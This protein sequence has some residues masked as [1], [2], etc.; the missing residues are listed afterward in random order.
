MEN[1]GEEHNMPKFLKAFVFSAVIISVFLAGCGTSG[2]NGGSSVVVPP[3]TQGS[4]SVVINTPVANT[5]GGNSGSITINGAG[6]T[7]PFPLYSRWFYDYAFV[8]PAVK[9]NYQAIGSGGG[10]KQITAKTVDFGASDAILT[11]EQLSAAPNLHMFPSVAG[12]EVIAYN[13]SGADGKSLTGL[14]KFPGTSLADIYLGKIKKWNDPVLQQANPDVQLP[15]KDIIV[16]HRSDGSGTTF[17]F[18]DYLS[19]ISPEWQSKV[20]NATSVQWPVGLGGKGNDGVAG[21]VSQNDGALGY[22]ELAY[23]L[24]NKLA[25]GVPANKSGNY[26]NPKDPKVVQNAMADFGSDLGDKLAISIVNAPGAQ[27]YPISGYTYLLFYMDQTDCA[28]AAKLVA[29]Y[30]W[31]QSDGAKDATDLDYIALPDAVKSQ[32]IKKLSQ[33]T[34]NGKPVGGG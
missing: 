16:V 6:A 19:K 25:Y 1:K 24:Q 10:I 34:C 33:M 32:A 22:V 27:S 14:L 11:D 15:D 26:L 20:G 21:T 3:A 9:F 12:A 4:S 31:A 18:T 29:F 7:F 13:L 2:S 17:I 30:K 5:G 8:D 28:K 23:A